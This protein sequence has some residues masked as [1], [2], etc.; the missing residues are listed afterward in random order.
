MPKSS[1]D[2]ELQRLLR[3]AGWLWLGYLAALMLIDWIIYQAFQHMEFYYL[4]NGLAALVFLGLAYW[5]ALERWLKKAYLPLA[6]AWIV[7]LP[8]VMNSLMLS[9]FQSGPM[10]SPEGMA[11]RQLPVLFVALVITAWQ[12][13][14]AGVIVFSGLTVLLELF[15]VIFVS[16]LIVFVS[17]AP[18]PSTPHEFSP[19][20]F[21]SVDMFIVLALVRTVSFMVVGTFFSQLIN[22][23]RLQQRSLADANARLTHYA[24]TLESLTVSRERN[25]MAH[26]LHDTL[27]H[28]LT[29]LSVQLETVKAY[30]S[31]DNQKSR[32]LL[33]QSLTATRSGLEETRRALKS[34]RATPLEEM[35]LRLALRQLAESAAKRGSLDLELALPD[36]LPYLSPDV[37]QCIYR[38]AQE[39]IEN[40]LA[41]AGA[42]HLT[43]NLALESQSI[44]LTVRDDGKGFD[45]ARAEKA[46]HFGLMGMRERAE[47]AGG[48]L[49]VDSNPGDGTTVTLTIGAAL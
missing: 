6:L 35:G 1:T 40:A 37:E 8:L 48:T 22:R 44:M 10:F 21:R 23:L 38:I 7:G 13:G 12:Y 28:S 25:R 11:L 34:L 36:P 17:V 33:D 4:V 46:G 47:I 26:E 19:T 15:L 29:A 14:L 18:P 39:S 41:H 31:V 27:A 16:P 30:W 42:K 5:S 24:S 3:T 45:P 43:V 9:G 32:E 2:P 20:S 49:S